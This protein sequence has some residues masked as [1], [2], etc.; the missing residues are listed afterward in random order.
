MATTTDTR[1]AFSDAQLQELVG[2]IKDADSVELKLTVPEARPALDDRGARPRSAA[3]RRSARCS[4]STRLTWRSTSTASSCARGGRRRRAT[5]RSSSCGRSCPSS[6][7]EPLRRSPSFGVE[8]DASPGGF[9]C[10]GSLKGAPDA[11]DVQEAVDRASFRFASS[12]RRSSGR[13][14][15]STRPRESAL[16]DLSI[17]GPILVLKLK[18]APHGFDRKLVG[19]LWLYPDGSRILELSTKCA[20]SEAFQVAAETRAFLARAASTSA[21]SSRR[22]RGRRS[23]SS[24]RTSA[25]EGY[26]LSA[27]ASSRRSSTGSRNSTS[28]ST[29]RC[30]EMSST[31]R[32]RNQSQTRSTSFSGRRGARGQ[33]DRFGLVQPGHVDVGLVVDQV[34]RTPL[35]RATSTSRFEL[36]EFATRSRAGGRPRR[37]GPSRPTAGWRSRNRCP[38][39]S[40]RRCAGSGGGAR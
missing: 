27:S 3:R 39:S 8:V 28:S 5:T 10:S 21:A 13:S 29:T 17:L 33:P 1:A 22:R 37:A 18:F 35:A 38:L 14:S 11:R 36:D 12:S 32:A 40:A 6:C 15:P 25:P 24:R 20:P 30:A 16:D 19:E 9:V 34:R 4:S 31:P 26:W 23:S 2:L 7:R